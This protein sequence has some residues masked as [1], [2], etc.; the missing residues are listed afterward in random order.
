MSMYKQEGLSEDS[1]LGTSVYRIG[2]VQ[3]VCCLFV[4]FFFGV[5]FITFSFEIC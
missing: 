5:V 4:F 3:V 1:D 2:L